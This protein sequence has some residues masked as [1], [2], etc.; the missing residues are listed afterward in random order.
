MPPGGGAPQARRRHREGTTA[1]TSERMLCI[2][3][4]AVVRPDETV[5]RGTRADIVV[6]KRDLSRAVAAFRGGRAVEF[7]A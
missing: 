7:E 1:M 2:Q 4:G 3:G 5:E 6:M